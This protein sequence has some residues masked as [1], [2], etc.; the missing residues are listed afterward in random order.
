M[1]K[2]SSVACPHCQAGNT[3][4]ALFCD[5][6]GNPLEVR[7][8]RCGEG[9]RPGAKFCKKCGERLVGKVEINER[10]KPGLDRATDAGRP[11][12]SVDYPGERKRVTV[13][14]ADIRDSTALIEKLDPEDVRKQFD[15][16][17]QIMMEAVHRYGG[18]VNQVLG[19]GIMALFGAPLAHEDHAVRACYAALAMQEE[20][21]R[22]AERIASAAAPVIRIGIGLNSG[23]VVVR[24]LSN[25]L[26]FDYSAQGQTTHVAARMQEL[27]APGAI[28]LTSASAREVEGLVKTKSLGAVQVKGISQPV[29]IFELNGVTAARTR[30]QAAAQRG[31]T[32]FIGRQTEIETFRR[33]T[34][35]VV[36]DGGQILAMVGEAGMG[37]SR[38]VRE[39]TLNHLPPDW[40]VFVGSSVSYGKATAYFPVIE[41]L[42]RYFAVSDKEIGSSI[43]TK[44]IDQVRQ[45][46]VTLMDIVPP[47]LTLLDAL[48]E[49][50]GRADSARRSGFEQSAELVELVTR[51]RNMEPPQ[52]RR[53]TLD[54]VKRLL[55]CESQRQPLLV[56]FEDLHWIDGETQAFLDRVV[57]SLPS[58]RI[59]LLVNY[60]LGYKHDWGDRA[61]Y[62]HLRV[63][64]LPRAGADVLLQSLL[65]PNE[66]LLPLREVLIERTGGNPFFTEEIVR[67]LVESGALSGSKGAYKPGL[68]L[69][70]IGIPGTVLSVL[71]DR[72][73]RL[74]LEEKQLLQCAAAIGVIVP[75]RL[76]RAV[77]GL[78][79]NDLYRCLAN[80]QAAEFIFE[81]KL[82]PDVEYSFTHALT[83]EVAYGALLH[84][85]RAAL[86]RRILQALEESSS[87]RPEDSVD[88]L[89]YHAMRAE[90]WDKASS[91]QKQAGAKAL[92]RSAFGDALANYERA[93]TALNHIPE[94]RER[95]EMQIDLHLDCRNVLFM[96]GDLTRVGEHLQR[97]EALALLLGDEQKIARVQNFLNS[98]YG[99][100]GDP[101]RAIA[102]GERTLALAVTRDNSALAAVTHYYLGVAYKQEGQYTKASEM[103]RRSVGNIDHQLRYERFGTAAVLSVTS[104]S[105]LVQC[106]TALGQFDDGIRVGD[107][108]IRIAEEVNHPPSLI[109]VSCSVGVLYLVKGDVELATSVLERAREICQ[110]ANVPVYLPLVSSRLGLAYAHAGRI[111][112]AIAYLQDGIEDLESAGRLSFLSLSTVWLA[113]GYL[114]ADR[115]DEAIECADRAFELSRTH[116]ERGH[117]AWALQLLGDIGLRRTSPQSAEAESCYRRALAL[118][119]ELGIRPVEAHCRFSLGKIAATRIPQGPHSELRAAAEL[120]RAM[121]MASW[122]ARAEAEL[123]RL[124]SDNTQNV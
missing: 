122:L 53:H 85:Q 94:S 96:L 74:P 34:E 31:L 68:R 20:M 116:K 35:N 56:V 55:V 101:E 110:T 93:F 2:P 117:Q 22:G 13:M 76:L 52:R 103:L 32:P 47:I 90:L 69:E 121:G 63:N 123:D 3:V 46:D 54:S 70:T 18:T 27:A 75:S 102:I 118:S 71:A 108:G 60:R 36:R 106:L 81:S 109:H 124:S 10:E 15:P 37:K 66:D 97:A 51:F 5:E 67:A 26:N 48:L 21:R 24:S 105:H 39:F 9:N 25:D 28:L 78:A 64:P 77:A 16:V 72:I 84:E 107:E 23:E 11:L 79:D 99:L 80:L 49:E 65:G 83:N 95:T 115:L 58:T 44:V 89:A 114:M 61:Y 98:Y 120:Y 41:S 33:L 92:S 29:E 82:F 45:L 14:F 73:D 91:Y 86:H 42:R 119:V 87:S 6:C 59:L 50:T 19:D 112:E 30:L 113:R 62:H 100:I 38:L 104:R 57:D 7:C 88:A 12:A 40:R 17:L 111:P 1:A 4:D 43:R 8:Q